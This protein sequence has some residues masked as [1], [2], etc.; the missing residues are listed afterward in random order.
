MHLWLD[1]FCGVMDPWVLMGLYF[2][3]SWYQ[4]FLL[5]EVP[6]VEVRISYLTGNSERKGDTQHSRVQFRSGQN[7]YH[8]WMKVRVVPNCC[9]SMPSCYWV[10]KVTNSAV[11]N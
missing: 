2:V 5:T 11:I 1:S 7:H 10:Q 8:V 4:L 3:C 6:Y 9:R